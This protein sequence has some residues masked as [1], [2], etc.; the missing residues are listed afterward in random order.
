MTK[1]WFKET[2]SKKAL[3]MS[4]DTLMETLKEL[5]GDFKKI[6]IIET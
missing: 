1:C 6:Y 3:L 4:Y 2:D 5:M